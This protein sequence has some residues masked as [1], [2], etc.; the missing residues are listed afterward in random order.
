MI[1]T[2]TVA[3]EAV[4]GALLMLHRTTTGPA[5]PVWV[6]V[7]LGDPALEKVPVPPLTTLHAPVPTEGVLPPKLAVV[8]FV[9]IV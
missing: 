1:V 2:A 5:P 6:K 8:P 4:Q 7:E 3:V 9:Q